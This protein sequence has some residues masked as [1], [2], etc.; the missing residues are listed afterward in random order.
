MLIVLNLNIR[1]FLLISYCLFRIAYLGF[2]TARISLARSLLME[3]KK[4]FI[5]L[6]ID[7]IFIGFTLLRAY[8]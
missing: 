4:L 3:Q 6:A 2:G 8:W 1:F 5:P 7:L